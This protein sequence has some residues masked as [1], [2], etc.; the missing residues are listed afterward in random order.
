MAEDDFEAVINKWLADVEDV[1]VPNV[2]RR[3]EIT[4]AA[5]AEFKKALRAETPRSGINYSGRGKR[6]GHTK[7]RK[8]EHL[9]DAITYKAGFTAEGLQ[10]G[11]TDVGYRDHYF[12][13]VARITNSGRRTRMSPKQLANLHFVDRAT[14][15]AE[16]AMRAAMLKKIRGGQ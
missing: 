3:S 5:A 15:N 1:A 2:E 13:F 8:R 14:K 6:A 12:D 9:Q 7:L 4:G 16:T 10:T 11:D